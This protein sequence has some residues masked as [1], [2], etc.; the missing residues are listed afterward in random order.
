MTIAQFRSVGRQPEVPSAL[1]DELRT[2]VGDQGWI[3]DPA[4]LEPQLRD[5]VGYAEGMTPIMVMPKNTAEVAAV[6]KACVVAGIPI[7]P[8]GGNTGSVA[9]AIPHGEVL[10][11]LRRMNRIR[12]IDA[13]DYTMTV[14]AGVVLAEMAGG[15]DMGAAVIGHAEEHNRVAVDVAGVGEGLL[16]ALPHAVDDRRLAR[17][18]GRAMIEFPGLVNDFHMEFP[19]R[20]LSPRPRILCLRLLE[21]VARH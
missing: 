19:P 12:D 10:L 9:G 21:A 7:V 16:M 2:I 4:D 5:W 14:D 8:Q 6:V 20:F 18:G 15:V 11:S 1:I 13:A 17:I 3:S